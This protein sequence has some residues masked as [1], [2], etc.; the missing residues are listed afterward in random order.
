MKLEV[1]CKNCNEFINLN[2]LVTDRAQL[3]F[4][5][6]KKIELTCKKCVSRNNYHPNELRAIK[7]KFISILAF[8][9]SIIGTI[10]IL[11]FIREYYFD[12]KEY[13]ESNK[14]YSSVGK[15]FGFLVIPIIVY[16]LI[17]KSQEKNIK[18]FNSYKI[19]EN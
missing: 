13:I 17:E 14:N 10:T 7:N 8:L 3:A 16:Q 12:H 4:D 6:G 9:I 5:K 11:Y 1:K 18:R 15:L 2:L 19:K